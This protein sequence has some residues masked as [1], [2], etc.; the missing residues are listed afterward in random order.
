MNKNQKTPF[1]KLIYKNDLATKKKIAENLEYQE[2]VFWKLEE[3]FHLDEKFR[4]LVSVDHKLNYTIYT[5]EINEF[6]GETSAITDIYSAT[7]LKKINK[8]QGFEPIY[9]NG[10]LLKKENDDG[11]KFVFCALNPNRFFIDYQDINQSDIESKKRISKCWVDSD[12]NPIAFDPEELRAISISGEDETAVLNSL[13]CA[14]AEE[15][16]LDGFNK[17]L[18]LIIVDKS[19]E[20]N[21][22]N[23]VKCNLAGKIIDDYSLL[24]ALND[25]LNEEIERRKNLFNE[26]SVSD[27]ESYNKKCKK[28]LP[29]ILVVFNN[30]MDIRNYFSCYSVEYT[31]KLAFIVSRA[32]KMGIRMIFA[33][34]CK[35]AHPFTNNILL[36]CSTK[37]SYKVVTSWAS[38]GTCIEGLA[39]GLF[40]EIDA[41]KY[42]V[43]GIK[44]LIPCHISDDC[45]N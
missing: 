16:E 24:F 28:Q 43:N 29:E 41:V 19:G 6:K 25:W 32:I 5:Y 3:F 7:L 34:P 20:F 13:K 9:C 11:A 44:R 18:K 21:A 33:S 10:M 12:S 17:N 4:N 31:V 39:D 27:F 40:K 14:V 35:T 37:F 15:I 2:R 26:L 30:F 22:L 36:R 1:E 42:S 38:A 45:F 8:L 23:G